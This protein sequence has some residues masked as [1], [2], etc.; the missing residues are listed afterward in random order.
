VMTK[1]LEKLIA[2]V[3][4]PE[5]KYSSQSKHKSIS[6][7]V[8]E[9]VLP[10]TKSQMYEEAKERL[11]QKTTA[12]SKEH[13]T[14]KRKSE[15]RATEKRKSDKPKKPAAV[16]TIEL[17]SAAAAVAGAASIATRSLEKKNVDELKK[18]FEQGKLVETPKWVGSADDLIPFVWR[19]PLI[20]VPKPSKYYRTSVRTAKNME[21]NLPVP[22]DKS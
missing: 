17:E 14:E 21:L 2:D 8:P 10:K 3:D 6:Y 16:K 13:I 4:I 20:D 22:R 12:A 19:H 9:I 5:M 15:K 18:K 11:T 1:D 7:E